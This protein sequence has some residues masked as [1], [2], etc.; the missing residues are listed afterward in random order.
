LK[1]LSD[2]RFSAG[3]L[4]F[5]AESKSFQKLFPKGIYRVNLKT[6]GVASVGPR[7]GWI[8]VDGKSPLTGAS[9]SDYSEG[10][11]K[12]NLSSASIL[13]FL[14]WGTW[15]TR[16]G[17]A[18]VSAAQSFAMALNIL[19]LYSRD[20]TPPC[21]TNRDEQ[22]RIWVEFQRRAAIWRAL[23]YKPPISDE[24]RQQRLLAE[25]EFKQQRFN[26]AAA[27]YETGLD[28][29]QLWPE[30]HFNV[31]MMYGELKQYDD[32]AWHMR[33]YLELSPNAP[34]A[35]EARDQI[36]LWEGKARRQATVPAQK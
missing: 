5:Q 35:Q 3:E 6:L 16:K 30:G 4:E 27:A 36:L 20:L 17:E 12:K 32:A 15:A 31:A 8:D 2:I 7:H 25:S 29:N 19:R 14:S 11:I 21:F 1:S 10:N 13:G 18:D 28:I 24:V 9:P 34:D 26:E 23:P 22:A 33:C